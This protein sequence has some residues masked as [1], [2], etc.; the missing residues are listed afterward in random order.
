MLHVEVDRAAERAAASE[1]GDGEAGIAKS[2]AKLE[3]ASF[4]ERAPPAVVEQER[5]RLADLQVKLADI[6]PSSAS[7]AS[8]RCRCPTA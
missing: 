1:R 7:S 3:N 6:A 4:V 2:R 8:A 5:K